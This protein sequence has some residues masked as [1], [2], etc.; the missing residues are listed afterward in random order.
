ML[1]RFSV[2]M[3][4]F[5]EYDIYGNIYFS[6]MLYTINSKTVRWF[7][8]KLVGKKNSW[9]G[10]VCVSFQ[11]LLFCF[12][13]FSI[14]FTRNV[15]SSQQ[16]LCIFWW[17]FWKCIMKWSFSNQDVFEF[18]F[19]MLC[20]SYMW[21]SE[22]QA[23]RAVNRATKEINAIYVDLYVFILGICNGNSQ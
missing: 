20:A 12:F 21:D 11:L 9:K 3:L 7:W 13:F 14:Y 1:V 8:I 10:W 18:F 5:H 15:I 2:C 17:T 19:F 4:V 16:S 22:W 23:Q 6:Y